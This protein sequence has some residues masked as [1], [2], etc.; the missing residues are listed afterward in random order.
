MEYLLFAGY[1]FLF[2][3]LVTRI[4]FFKKTGLTNAQLVILFL[5]KIMAGILYGWIGIYYGQFAY[6]YDTWGFHYAG[7]EETKI[8]YNRPAEYFSNLFYSGYENKFG[9][10]LD[11]HNSWWNDLKNNMFVKLLSLINIFSFGNYY[12]NVIFYS[13]ISLFGPIAFFRVMNDVYPGKKLIT[14]LAVFLIPSFAYWTSG[15]HKDGLVF[16]AISLIVYHFYFG[17]KEKAFSFLRVVIIFISLL[18]ILSFRNYVFVILVPALSAWY[19]VYVFPKRKI[20]VFFSV[21]S[22]SVLLF[23]TLHYI[24]P[25]FDLPQ[26]VINKQKAFFQLQGN[27]SITPAVLEPRPFSFLKNLPHALSATI[28]RPYPADAKHLLSLA[29]AI[30][31]IIFL[32]LFI[33]FL[34][35]RK[36]SPQS[37]GFLWF[38]VFF[39]FSFLLTIGYTVNFLGAIVRYRSIVIPFLLGHIICMTDW[40]RISNL[41]FNNIK[42]KSNI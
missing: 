31:T 36:G 3:W 8:L 24:S 2:A 11:S 39:S 19:L 15:I 16:L 9:G 32:L 21:Y 5:I 12:T 37:K 33:C 6:M 27:S 1:L 40:K 41:V 25:S 13:F 17:L 35:W 4:G 42:N 22:V 14:L 10:F 23:F 30:E 34:I 38:C 26:A 18:I 29:A 7:L 20:T 28:L